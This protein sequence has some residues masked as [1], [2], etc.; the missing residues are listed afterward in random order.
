M[1]IKK[2]GGLRS[3]RSLRQRTRSAIAALVDSARFARSVPRFRHLD[4]ILEPILPHLVPLLTDLGPL[5]SHLG[6]L[7]AHLPPLLAYLGPLLSQ[8]GRILE[9]NSPKIEKH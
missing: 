3:L 1:L 7:L 6:D 9:Q 2:V 4:L 5:L 8:L